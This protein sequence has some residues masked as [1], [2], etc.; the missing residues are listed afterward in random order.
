MS[1]A[2]ARKYARRRHHNLVAKAQRQQKAR[3][4][5]L[6]LDITTLR[7]MSRG[8]VSGGYSLRKPALVEALIQNGVAA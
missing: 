5:L 7:Q 8:V 1:T 2:R 6:A 4:R 3:Q